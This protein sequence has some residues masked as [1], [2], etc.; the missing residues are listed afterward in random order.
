MNGVGLFP[1]LLISMAASAAFALLLGIPTVK[2]RG[3]YLAIVT[4]GAA[5]DSPDDRAAREHQ[6]HHW[7]TKRN[8]EHT[9][10]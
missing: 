3:D 4:I 2:L 6:P 9:V 1:A 5:G 8:P 7:R 10:P